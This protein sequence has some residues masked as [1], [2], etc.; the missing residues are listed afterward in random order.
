M[1]T[2]SNDRSIRLLAAAGLAVGSLLGLAGSFVPT[3]GVRGLAWGIDGTALIV[4]SALLALHFFR[5]GQDIVAA[6][7]IVFA[8]GEGI[9]V[10]G[11]A[12]NLLASAPSFGAGAGL[13]A[14][15]LALISVPRVFPVWNRFAGLLA[16]VL[17]AVTAVQILSGVPLHAKSQPLPFFAYPVFVATMCGWIWALLRG[18]PSSE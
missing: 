2:E 1:N 6:G 3:E 11:S 18:N 15:A 12:M 14:A 9:I 7:F 17:F 16:A 5:R 8:V 4:A 10:S 13:W